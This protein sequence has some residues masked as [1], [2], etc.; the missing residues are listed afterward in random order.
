MTLISLVIQVLL[1]IPLT[2]ILNYCK[3]KNNRKIDLIL[4]PTIY[5]IIMTALIPSIKENAYLIVV[6][7]SINI[8]HG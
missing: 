1:T 2:I 4:I 6:R 7:K 3:N 5:M 8:Y